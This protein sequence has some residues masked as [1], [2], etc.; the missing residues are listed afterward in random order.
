MPAQLILVRRRTRQGHEE[1]SKQK[2]AETDKDPQKEKKVAQPAEDQPEADD[3]DPY[4]PDWIPIGTLSIYGQH[5]V[6]IGHFGTVEE[7]LVSPRVRALPGGSNTVF[8]TVQNLHGIRGRSLGEQ[9]G[10]L[11][12]EL[13]I[14]VHEGE[15][16]V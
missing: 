16:L 5:P 1:K 14:V 3:N 2:A 15:S 7:V 9:L 11:P 10:K 12:N 4:G 8:A 13:T 6:R